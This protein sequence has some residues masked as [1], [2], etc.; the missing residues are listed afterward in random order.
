M[1]LKYKI[2]ELRNSGDMER[3]IDTSQ[4]LEEQYNILNNNYSN[5]PGEFIKKMQH[6]LTEVD[7][8]S[9]R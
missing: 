4:R 9:V 1:M 2:G 6:L 8:L 5:N 7:N 3:I